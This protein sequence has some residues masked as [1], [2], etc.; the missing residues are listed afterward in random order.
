MS[1]IFF[2]YNKYCAMIWLNILAQVSMVFFL[3]RYK[4][5]NEKISDLVKLISG[6][7]LENKIT[8]LQ[9]FNILSPKLF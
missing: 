2:T 8:S 4:H 9:P 7:Q 3:I 6:L 5:K 1:Q